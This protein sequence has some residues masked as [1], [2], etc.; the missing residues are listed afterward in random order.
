MTCFCTLGTNALHKQERHK[1]KKVP[2]TQTQTLMGPTKELIAKALHYWVENDDNLTDKA[3]F[4]I[5][6]TAQLIEDADKVILERKM[7]I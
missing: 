6:T 2:I 5:E 4:C 7:E 1:M 3:K